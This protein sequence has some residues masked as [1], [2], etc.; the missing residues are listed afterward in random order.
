MYKPV[1]RISPISQNKAQKLPCS[2]DE[3]Q[4]RYRDRYNL[5]ASHVHCTHDVHGGNVPCQV[6]AMKEGQQ[7]V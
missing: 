1:P 7:G 3:Y 4:V 6:S 2:T 5:T